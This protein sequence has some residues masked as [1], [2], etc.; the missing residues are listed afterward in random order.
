MQPRT[1]G[2]LA[3]LSAV[4]LG[5][6][7][8]VIVERTRLER[9]PPFRFRDS[10]DNMQRGPGVPGL[11]PGFDQLD[12]TAEQEQQ[13]DSIFRIWEPRGRAMMDSVMPRLRALR[14]SVH[15]EVES[16]LTEDQRTRLR[17]IAPLRP[18]SPLPRRTPG[19]ARSRS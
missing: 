1:Q 9:R 3:I 10:P 6:A 5:L 8:G 4:L 16:V 17:E 15:L 11:P 12:L 7:A 18:R 13:I 14:D 19:P 2:T